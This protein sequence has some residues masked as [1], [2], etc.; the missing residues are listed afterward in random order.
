MKLEKYKVISLLALLLLV[1]VL[2]IYA[3]IEPRRMAQAQEELRQEFV[4][5]AA[6]LYVENCALCHGA[7]GEGIGATPGLDNEGL[8]TADYDFLF[9]TIARGR[10]DTT[11]SAWHSEEG[12]IFNDYQVDELVALIRYVDWSQVREL[13]AAEGLIPPT[14]PVPEIEEEF[15]QEIAALGP[16]GNTWAEG[17]S[18]YANNCT[19]CHGINGEGSD[20]GLP[21]NTAELRSREAGELARII[22]EGVPGTAMAGWK[23]SLSV[24]EIDKLVAFLHNWDVI[25]AQGLELQAPQPIHIDLNNPQEVLALG[26]NIYNSTCS[27]CHGENGSGGTGPALNSLQFLTNKNDD[28]I[29]NTIINGSHRPN[30]SMPAFGDRFTAVELAALVD[31]IRAWE[32]TATWVENPRGTEQGGGPPWLRAT[33]D[34]NNP[35]S[36]GQG[37]GQGRGQ[38]QGQGQGGRGGGPPWR[39]NTD[40]AQTPDQVQPAPAGQGPTNVG[41]TNVGPTI[42]VQ[43]DVVTAE[44]N[45][46]AVI[47]DE[48]AIVDAML[49]PP[50][51]W[52]ESGIPLAPGD[53]VEFEGF[54]SADHMEVNWLTNLTTGQTIQLRTAE[55]QPVW[56]SGGG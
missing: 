17:M 19:V 14:L 38:G 40:T 12:G 41:P 37:Q 5:D 47:T 35:V 32:P 48:S 18:L 33:P 44:G 24:Q 16:E 2:P 22:G 42:F 6:V 7:A 11:M 46:L 36:P 15:L 23:N 43:G 10:Y 27:S 50:W 53:R 9:K 51:F 34:P 4:S 54:E 45:R 29:T 1:I 3:V 28:Q 25:E 13:A 49:G 52:S 30:S 21:L 39:Q 55:G 31:F 26:E 20:L 8:R 56:S